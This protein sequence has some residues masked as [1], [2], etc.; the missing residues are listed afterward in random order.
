[1]N[2][3]GVSIGTSSIGWALVDEEAK[4]I[5]AQGV[6]VFPAGTDGDIESGQDKSR[7]SRRQDA[8]Q[9]RVQLRRRAGR[10]RLLFKTLQASG[11]FP[12]GKRQ[13]VL[14]T[15]KTSPYLLRKKAL[16]ERLAPYEL[17]RILYH[18]AHRRGFKSNKKQSAPDDEEKAKKLGKV[19]QGIQD[20]SEALDASGDRTLGEYLLR[21]PVKRRR[22][23][24]RSMYEKEV[25]AILLTQRRFHDIP[26]VEK[27]LFD[28]KPLRSQAGRVGPCL[29]ERSKRRMELAHLLAQEFRILQKVNDLRAVDDM[30]AETVPLTQE[31]R[32]KVVSHL[33]L[34]GD[35]TFK[36]IREL[37]GLP[38]TVRF[39]FERQ[40][41]EK[42]AE[43]RLI[44]DRTRQSLGLLDPGAVDDFLQISEEKGLIRRL[45]EV[46]G[47][48][49]E[50]AQEVAQ[51]QVEAGYLMHSKKAVLKLLPLMRRGTAYATA[52]K[53]VYGDRGEKA[54]K[55]IVKLYSVRRIFPRLNNPLVTRSLGELHKVVNALVKKYGLPGKIRLELHRDLH[56]GP[57]KRKL[58]AKR[59]FAQ[60]KAKKDASAL[61]L[62][63]LGIKDPAPWQVER[64]LLANEC[65]WTCPFTGKGI[66]LRT[67]LRGEPSFYAMHLV[68]FHL[69]LDDSFANKTLAHVS[70]H[71]ARGDK[72]LS[73]MY[74]KPKE[75]E[76]R[77]KDFKGPL[78]KEKLRRFKLPR[79]KMIQE[80]DDAYAERFLEDGAYSATL[81]REYLGKFYGSINAVEATR[82]RVTNFIREAT[83][84]SRVRRDLDGDHRQRVIDAVAVAVTDAGTFKKLSIAAKTGDRRRFSSFSAPWETFVEDVREAVERTLVSFRVTRRVRGP[85]HEETNYSFPKKDKDGNVYH[86]VR[87]PLASITA[88]DVGLIEGDKIRECVAK[89]FQPKA[90][91]DPENLP[92]FQG[93][94]VRRVHVKRTEGT[95]CVGTGPQRR[96]VTNEQNHHALV[97]ETD[98]GK[99]VRDIVS[100]FEAQRRLRNG[101]PIYNEGLFSI[102]TGEIFRVD[103]KLVRIRSVSKDTRISYVPLSDGRKL[104]TIIDAKELERQTVEQ[105]R[106]KGIRKVSIDPIGVERGDG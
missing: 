87:K 63:E 68:P 51:A 56:T 86:V 102:S 36:T 95:F 40:D 46:H 92:K 74:S 29:L 33:L 59:M 67:L 103:G 60:R 32:K 7:N 48:S 5:V 21:Q 100:L 90:F 69:S 96:Y 37:L 61:L 78:A 99:W 91:A 39:N 31:M 3:L 24:A 17:G 8:R 50:R 76:A 84:L 38:K 6:R 105:L 18:L 23:T 12:P 73:E 77:F 58:A 71:E 70:I 15:V 79:E 53:E 52:V 10:L 2:L 27:I 55:K 83:G 19:L 26:R 20:L 11:F 62:K 101:E 93:S 66:S 16:D 94:V 44:G 82:T 45:V 30:G 54:I 22:W 4:K 28:Q 35:S 104:E 9:R 97:R 106:K 43:K 65:G 1:M 42:K 57:K 81:A 41:E 80:Y 64:V 89:A 49:Q 75:I 88:S 47:L 13:E 72:I 34:N 14:E 85:L 98:S 25:V